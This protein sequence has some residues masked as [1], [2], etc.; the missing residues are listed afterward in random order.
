MIVS[1]GRLKRPGRFFLAVLVC[2]SMTA[3]AVFGVLGPA[4]AEAPDLSK[5][6]IDGIAWFEEPSRRLIV[7][8][9]TLLKEGMMF[10]DFRVTRIQEDGVELEY[11]GQRYVKRIELDRERPEMAETQDGAGEKR[12]SS[13]AAASQQVDVPDSD[14]KAPQVTTRT[15]AGPESEAAMA[16]SPTDASGSI[17]PGSDG[18]AGSTG[19]DEVKDSVL[20]RMNP[21]PDATMPETGISSL[22]DEETVAVSAEAGQTALEAGRSATGEQ[23]EAAERPG[24][25]GFSATYVSTASLANVRSGPGAGFKVIARIA[26]GTILTV[27]EV[28]GDWL[29]LR[30]SDGGTGWLHESLAEKAGKAVSSEQ[31]V[32]ETES[33]AE[34]G[35]ETGL[36]NSPSLASEPEAAIPSAGRET[37]ISTASLANVRSGPGAGFDV[38]ARIEAGTFVTVVDRQGEWLKLRLSDDGIGWLHSSLAEKR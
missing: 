36:T 4:A 17:Q 15:A 8:N 38:V 14:I 19:A 35:R 18:S 25:D 33:G 9:H 5:L 3:A 29:R 20:G 2:L 21:A 32:T 24:Q 34:Q 12:R 23:A 37:W 31:M 22:P 1:K 10:G 13:E 7:I 28:K 26:Q 11:Q 16:G 27:D 30:M 6:K